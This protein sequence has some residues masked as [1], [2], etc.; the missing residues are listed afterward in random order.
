[1]WNR[2]CRRTGRYVDFYL[3]ASKWRGEPKNM[4]P[5]KCDELRWFDEK[6]LPKNIIGYI[7]VVIAKVTAGE[8]YSAYGFQ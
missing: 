4:E 8:P 5:G 3:T 2:G 6:S 1:M 7:P